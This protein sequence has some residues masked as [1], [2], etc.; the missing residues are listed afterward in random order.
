MQG[1]IRNMRRIRPQRPVSDPEIA[2]DLLLRQEPD[3]EED[4]DEDEGDGK[5]GRG[6]SRR[7]R[8]LPIGLI[9]ILNWG[10]SSRASQKRAKFKDRRD[11]E[12]VIFLPVGL[13]SSQAGSV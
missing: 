4:E 11:P 6:G 12:Y 3:E 1:V 8:L 5:E 2:G 10:A 7:R 9:L 13:S